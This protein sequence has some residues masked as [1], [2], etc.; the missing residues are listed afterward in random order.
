MIARIRKA[1]YRQMQ[2]AQKIVYLLV[3]IFILI[4]PEIKIIFD[5]NQNY[6][7]FKII[8]THNSWYNILVYIVNMFNTI[9]KI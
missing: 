8:Q 2:L 6:F 1:A 9:K 5:N 7:E 4:C 3:S